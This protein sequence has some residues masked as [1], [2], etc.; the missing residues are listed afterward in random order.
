[1]SSLSIHSLFSLFQFVEY[2]SV[3]GNRSAAASGNKTQLT[4]QQQ[5]PQSQPQ[6]VTSASAST[7]GGRGGGGGKTSSSFVRGHSRSS[8]GRHHSS[9]NHNHRGGKRV[10]FSRSSPQ[11]FD[12]GLEEENNNY[13]TKSLAPIL[14]PIP[15]GDILPKKSL[16][17]VSSSLPDNMNR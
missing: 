1:M 8:T 7:K 10:H 6:V 14:E 2:Q 12:L 11:I 16:L 5:Q 9:H 17:K 3:L 13:N 15:N 4:Q